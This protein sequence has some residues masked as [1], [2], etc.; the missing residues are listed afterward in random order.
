MFENTQIVIISPGRT[1]DFPLHLGSNPPGPH[2]A[3]SPPTPPQLIPGYATET[4]ALGPALFLGFLRSS[5]SQG[6]KPS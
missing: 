5:K 6:N 2:E 3:P 4:R 1:P